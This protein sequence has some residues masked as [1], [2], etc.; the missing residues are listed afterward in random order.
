MNLTDDEIELGM[1]GFVDDLGAL[2]VFAVNHS[3]YREAAK[4]AKREGMNLT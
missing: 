4:S 2:T 1:G 3:A